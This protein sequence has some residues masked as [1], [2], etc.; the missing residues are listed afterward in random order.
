MVSRV[1]L[2]PPPALA[3]IR[4]ALADDARRAAAKRI[5]KSLDESELKQTNVR[6]PAK[7]FAG[8]GE[9]IPVKTA[10]EYRA[11]A[12]E[13]FRWAREAKANA[14]RGPL[15]RLAQAWLDAASKLD[16]LPAT[17]TEPTP[18][19]SSKTARSAD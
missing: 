5:Y 19:E 17:R 15:Q 10:A 14:V 12:E 6:K 7:D 13:C 18:D 4:Q 1:C 11:M 8:K 2:K 9:H 16:G 3:I